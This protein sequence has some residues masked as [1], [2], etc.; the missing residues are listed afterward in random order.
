[1][2]TS[3]FVFIWPEETQFCNRCIFAWTLYRY[4][5]FSSCTLKLLTFTYA[6][7]QPK[8]LKFVILQP[9]RKIIQ[10]V[11]FKI[12]KISHK[13]VIKIWCMIFLELC[14][15]H[16][17]RNSVK[18]KLNLGCLKNAGEILVHDVKWKMSNLLNNCDFKH[19]AISPPD[20]N[21][22]TF[23]NFIISYSP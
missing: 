23:N 10:G 2:L 15:F 16:H 4:Y 21:I 7:Y 11:Q 5:M 19:N 20:N 6:N 8:S 17:V 3:F 18:S 13:S 9:E 12:N 22:F 1:M 14:F